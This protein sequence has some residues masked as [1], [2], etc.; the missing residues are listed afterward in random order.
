MQ[1]INIWILAKNGV[2]TL[3]WMK[4]RA[5][6]NCRSKK[7][8]E[9]PH[10]ERKRDSSW[11]WTWLTLLTRNRIY[12]HGICV[13]LWRVRLYDVNFNLIEGF[14]QSDPSPPNYTFVICP[15]GTEVVCPCHK[16]FHTI[17]TFSEIRKVLLQLFRKNYFASKVNLAP[18][19]QKCRSFFVTYRQPHK[20]SSSRSQMSAWAKV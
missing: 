9:G 14:Q 12:Y 6:F 15:F 8:E 16:M 20:I 4:R 17:K 19:A 3:V 10:R 7:R 5:L 11:S 2:K 18:F 1:T 13:H